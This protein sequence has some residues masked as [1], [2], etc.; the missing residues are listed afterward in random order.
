MPDVHAHQLAVEVDEALA[1]RRPE[2]NALRARD[3]DRIHLRLRRPFEERV[4][5][6]ERDHLLAGHR[7]DRFNSHKPALCANPESQ[8]PNPYFFS[9]ASRFALNSVPGFHSGILSAC[10]TR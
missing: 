5:L 1:F 9:I 2:I 8:I 4:L 7:A 6:R 3:R 10:A